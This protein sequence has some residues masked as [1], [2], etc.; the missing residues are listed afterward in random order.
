MEVEDLLQRASVRPKL[1]TSST[2]SARQEMMPLSNN[3]AASAG[4]AVKYTSRPDAYLLT[5]PRDRR[6]LGWVEHAASS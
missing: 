2:S 5:G 4:S 3:T 1:A 6:S